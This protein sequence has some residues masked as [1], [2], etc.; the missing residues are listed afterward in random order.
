MHHK[1]ICDTFSPLQGDVST[2]P[3]LPAEVKPHEKRPGWTP[4]PQEIK[5][6]VSKHRLEVGQTLPS[7]VVVV[8]F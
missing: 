8:F 5:P 2:F 7:Y 6:S 1:D 3:Q 4:I